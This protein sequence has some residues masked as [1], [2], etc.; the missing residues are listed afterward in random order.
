MLW[1]CAVMT[2]AISASRPTRSTQCTTS[3]MACMLFA[4]SSRSTTRCTMPLLNMRSAHCGRR[5]S[6]RLQSLSTTQEGSTM[7]RDELHKWSKCRRQHT[8]TGKEQAIFM[9][10]PCT[11]MCSGLKGSVGGAAQQAGGAGRPG[12]Q[13]APATLS[14]SGCSSCS[15]SLM[16]LFSLCRA[17]R[18]VGFHLCIA[19]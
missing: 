10:M 12:K 6:K 3:H 19:K 5:V 18:V 14:G 7:S 16:N 17:L 11:Q 1:E 4:G 13:G 15:L 8:H 2:W 9:A